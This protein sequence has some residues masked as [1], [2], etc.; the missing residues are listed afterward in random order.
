[1]YPLRGFREVGSGGRREQA[2]VGPN[3]G[4]ECRQPLYLTA[5]F[6]RP[7][8]NAVRPIAL[9]LNERNAQHLWSEPTLCQFMG[10]TVHRSVC[11]R[12]PNDPYTSPAPLAVEHHCQA[13]NDNKHHRA[14]VCSA[15]GKNSRGQLVS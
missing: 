7:R 10:L 11:V 15:T 1:V 3:F 13:P 5:S 9:W 12:T 6:L 14:R 4:C 8:G 2:M